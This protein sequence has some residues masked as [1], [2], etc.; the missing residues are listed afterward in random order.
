MRSI[1]KINFELIARCNKINYCP[2]CYYQLLP[3]NKKNEILPLAVFIKFIEKIKQYK[4]N[5]INLSGGEPVIVQNLGEYIRIAQEAS[6]F[7]RVITNSDL[8]STDKIETLFLYGLK[9][10]NLSLNE[11]TFNPDLEFNVYIEKYIKKIFTMK[12]IGYNNICILVV[13]SKFSLKYITRII[14]LAKEMNIELYLQPL[15]IPQSKNELNFLIDFSVADLNLLTNALLDWADEDWRK[16]YVD[17]WLRTIIDR[18]KPDICTQG[19]DS[20]L[21]C[22]DGKVVPCYHRRDLDCGNIVRDDL[23]EIFDKLDYF[24]NKIGDANCYE[25]DCKCTGLYGY[26][27]RYFESKFLHK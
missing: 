26:Q 4:L 24:C 19:I 1:R 2:Y 11:L 3:D 7:V 17:V 23:H 13:V 10:I 5:N 25:L 9:S 14:Y 6:S 12:K 27:V 15:F 21:V 18:K 8:L 22:S 16:R 20:F